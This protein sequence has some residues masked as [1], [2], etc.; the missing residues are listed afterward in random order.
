VLPMILKIKN[1]YL[2]KST[3]GSVSVLLTKFFSVGCESNIYITCENM[4]L[5][6]SLNR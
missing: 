6:Y 3:T 2:T 5:K 1:G 4:I